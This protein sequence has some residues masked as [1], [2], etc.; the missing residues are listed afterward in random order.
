MTHQIEFYFSDELIFYYLILLD[1]SMFICFSISMCTCTGT[2]T[3]VLYCI[4]KLIHLIKWTV[5]HENLCWNMLDFK[6]PQAVLFCS[7]LV[8]VWLIDNSYILYLHLTREKQSTWRNQK[9][10]K[11]GKVLTAV[12]SWGHHTMLTL[13]HT[14]ITP[15][16]EAYW[17]GCSWL[18]HVGNL[19]FQC[20]RL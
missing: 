9:A 5:A 2:H 4:W 1:S 11:L 18:S 20:R 6:V 7:Y 19:T 3:C 17:C 10:D 15:T 13:L 16:P 8:P 12:D 14:F